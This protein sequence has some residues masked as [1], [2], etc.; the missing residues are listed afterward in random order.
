MC[1]T[2]AVTHGVLT[3]VSIRVAYLCHQTGFAREATATTHI[4]DDC[5]CIAADEVDECSLEVDDCSEDASCTDQDYGLTSYTGV[6]FTCSCKA[7]FEGDGKTCTG[8]SWGV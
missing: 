2:T 7:G 4:V 3:C 6:P 1:S 5:V 8:K